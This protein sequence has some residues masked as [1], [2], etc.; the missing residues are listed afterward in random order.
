MLDLFKHDEVCHKLT[1][2]EKFSGAELYR[3]EGDTQL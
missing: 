3:K 2:Y 1:A